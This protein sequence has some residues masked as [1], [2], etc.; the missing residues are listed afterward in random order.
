VGT[1]GSNRQGREHHKV[2]TGQQRH[3]GVEKRRGDILGLGIN[4]KWTTSRD[5]NRG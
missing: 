5:K 3:D 1:E 2:D 4:D